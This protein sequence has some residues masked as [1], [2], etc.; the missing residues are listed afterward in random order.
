MESR[1]DE[2]RQFLRVR[3]GRLLTHRA[4]CLLVRVHADAKG[5]GSLA[6]GAAYRGGT[7]PRLNV[8][9]VAPLVSRQLLP[10]IV[11]AAAW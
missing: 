6:D 8:T 9:V 5:A 7:G 3:R 1:R 10:V 11:T 4:P 2:L